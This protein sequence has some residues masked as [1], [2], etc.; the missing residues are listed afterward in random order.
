MEDNKESILTN[1]PKVVSY[2]YTK[3]IIDQMEKIYII[4]L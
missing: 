2:E 4:L 3:K 1:Y